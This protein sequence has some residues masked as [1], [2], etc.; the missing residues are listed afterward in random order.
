MRAL[1]S[2]M[3]IAL[4]GIAQAE[5]KIAVVNWQ[6]AVL[7]SEH[8]KKAS[9]KLEADKKD[10]L[11]TVE[12]LRAALEK[13]QERIKKDEAILSEDEL[14]KLKNSFEEKA[15]TYKFHHQN[16]Q[17][18]RQQAL[19]ELVQSME[20]QIKTAL[21]EIMK[22]KGFEVI[23]RPEAVILSTPAVDITKLLLQKL[24][25]QKSK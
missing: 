16:L 24:N 21:D 12:K 18:A 14:R 11:A 23:L 6:Q 8:A 13:L 4:A 22:E 17:K 15:T 5:S 7:A 1:I 20:P 10:E 19:A 2:V 9:E 3:L 25:E